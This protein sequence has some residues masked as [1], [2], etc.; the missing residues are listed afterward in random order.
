MA[1]AFAGRKAKI[2]APDSEP[3][4]PGSWTSLLTASSW[5][6]FL[7]R[8]LLRIGY[9]FTRI[10]TDYQALAGKAIGVAPVW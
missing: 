4:T 7:M 3:L 8:S 6:V 5:G 2:L 9:L 1:G 10:T